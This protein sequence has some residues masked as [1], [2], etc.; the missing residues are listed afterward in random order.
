[1][2]GFPEIRFLFQQ[3][4]DG[5]GDG[6]RVHAA[7]SRDGEFGQVEVAQGVG[8]V[9]ELAAGCGA[10]FGLEDALV[11]GGKGLVLDG[12]FLPGG[13]VFG[14]LALQGGDLFF[15]FEID[16]VEKRQ[17]MNNLTAAYSRDAAY[18]LR[19][20]TDQYLAGLMAAGA[21]SK[22]DPISGATATK[23]Y[24]T[25]VDLA[26]AL[27]KQNVPDAGRWVI[28]NP[29][30]YGL[31]RK[32]SR[33]VAGAESAHSTLLNG[34]VGE[35]AGMTILKSNN[36]PAAKG[37]SASAQTDEG[38]VIIAGTNA[39]TTFAEQI[40]KV[41]ATRKEKGFDD[42]VKGLH[43]YGAKVVRPEA[44]ATVHFKVGGK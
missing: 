35:A 26:T 4:A 33:F 10:D 19:D 25:I 43:L 27:D 23:A 18:K 31:L 1:M 32:D 39:A 14:F 36:A 8:R 30:F 12:L 37:G 41:E 5:V 16:D 20:L 24:D 29:D 34:V 22:L 11:G 13:L 17:A 9:G 40:A 38:N 7:V 3:F 44:L 21:K 2:L 6:L 42:I 28:V 15:E